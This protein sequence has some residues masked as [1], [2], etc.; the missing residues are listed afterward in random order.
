MKYTYLCKM[1]GVQVKVQREVQFSSV[2]LI[3][4]RTRKKASCLSI[5]M[6]NGTFQMII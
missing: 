4:S 2:K 6:Q 3:K 1:Y 5:V